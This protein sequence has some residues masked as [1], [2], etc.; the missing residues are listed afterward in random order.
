MN[1]EITELDIVEVKKILDELQ[2]TS[3]L[4]EKS[5]KMPISSIILNYI[6][7]DKSNIDISLAFV[8]LPENVFPNVKILQIFYEFSET[9]VHKNESLSLELTNR[10][11]Y[12]LS[13][14]CFGVKDNKITYRYCHVMPIFSNL[15]DQ[16]NSITD[17]IKMVAMYIE[18]FEKPISNVINGTLGIDEM[19]NSLQ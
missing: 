2:L 5:D 15:L 6:S 4:I 17:L 1:L 18:T 12:L 10:I 16:K 19:L 7:S 9:V 11:N 13:V 3:H 14:G 8:P